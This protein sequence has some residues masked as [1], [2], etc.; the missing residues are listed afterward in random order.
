MAD[1]TARGRNSKPSPLNGREDI[2]AQ[3]SETAEVDKSS[4]VSEYWE[5]DEGSQAGRKNRPKVTTDGFEMMRVLGKGCAGKVL[6][7]RHK[8]TLGL[9]AMKVTTKRNALAHQELQR[10]LTERDV[11][12]WMAV[13]GNNP[14]VM[15]LWWSF[16]D[17]DNLFLVTDFHPAGDLAAQLVRWG[18]FDPY[19]TRYYAAEIAEGV[20]CLHK[21]G[22]IHRD[23][24]PENVLIDSG[25]HIVLTGF[26][27][28]EFRRLSNPIAAPS[29]S[30]GI[31]GEPFAK[32][33]P[34]S[35]DREEGLPN[36][37]P[38]GGTKTTCTFSNAVEYLAPEV[39]QG[40]P[41][42]FEVDWWSFGMMLYEMLTGIVRTLSSSLESVIC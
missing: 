9:F 21:N 32:G 3:T 41:Y 42:S 16:Y 6:L 38:G 5:Y 28:S 17:R 39:I 8:S 40:L 25:G 31:R 12:K 19:T 36:G 30:D 2:P 1:P 33:V 29:T 27:L 22:I 7:V 26:G 18:K 14:F 37:I 35:P 15:K 24:R 4:I 20:G 13:E 11:L 23:L 34:P 10:A